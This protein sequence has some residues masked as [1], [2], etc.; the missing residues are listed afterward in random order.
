[1]G[2]SGAVFVPLLRTVNAALKIVLHTRARNRAPVCMARTLACFCCALLFS[3]TLQRYQADSRS[4]SFRIV[5]SGAKCVEGAR[6]SRWY[7]LF[8]AI[9][10][11]D[12]D[13]RLLT[14][15]ADRRITEIVTPADLVISFLTAITV[16]MTRRTL[17]ME[18]CAAQPPPDPMLDPEILRALLGGANVRFLLANGR[19]S[20]G[21]V[22][23]VGPND[24]VLVRA[25]KQRARQ[26][27]DRILRKDG[28]ELLGTIISQDGVSVVMVKSSG[29]RR[30]VPKFQIRRIQYGIFPEHSVTQRRTIAR[31]EIRRILIQKAE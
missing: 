29:L 31:G 6:Q 3:C 27:V 14:G 28:A 4:G 10:V 15:S 24:V 8:G 25:F 11:G 30:V 7:F 19:Y 23:E 2:P 22:A 21:K 16:T 18:A 1:M 13:P 9:P 12:P 20:E 5:G 26:P 17:V